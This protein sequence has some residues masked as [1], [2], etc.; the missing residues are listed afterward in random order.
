MLLCFLFCPKLVSKNGDSVLGDLGDE[1]NDPSDE[2]SDTGNENENSYNESNDILGLEITN[3]AVNACNE[4]SEKDLKKNLCD[5]GKV[6]ISF[7]DFHW[8]Y[9]FRI[10]IYTLIIH[11]RFVKINTLL[12]KN[13][14][15]SYKA[16]HLR[17]L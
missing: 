7:S 5:L 16:R 9:P 14:I 1:V 4:T 2:V 10:I 11:A 15:F 8:Y 13:V 3:D 12:Q 17:A 6:L